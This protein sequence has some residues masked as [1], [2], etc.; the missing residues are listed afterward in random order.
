VILDHYS[1]RLSDRD[2]EVVAH[3]PPGGNWRNLPDDFESKR[4]DQIRRS[5]AA[6]DGSR[7]TYYGRLRWDHPSYTI[8]TYFN[9]PGNG[10]FIHPEAPRLIT[11]REAARLQSFPDS[12]HFHGGGRSRFVQVGNA[13]PPLLGYQ[14][15]RTLEAGTVVD[16]FAGAGGLSLGFEM[17]GHELV[18][19]ADHDPNAVQTFNQNRDDERAYVLDFGDESGHRRAMELIQA[20]CGSE[21]PAVVIGGP[22]CQG[23]STAGNCAPDD[24]R[25]RLVFAFISAVESLQPAAV[26]MENVP[27]MLGQ[28][29]QAILAEVRLLLHNLGYRTSTIIA[30]AEGYGVPQLR[31][32]LFLMAR[33]DGQMHWPL[34][35]CEIMSPAQPAHQPVDRRALAK[36]PVHSVL[37]A[38]GDLPLDSVQHPDI[39]TVYRHEA[40]SPYQEW[41]RSSRTVAELI[42]TP[43]IHEE[44]EQLSLVATGR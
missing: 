18:A 36:A 32:R 20:R 2:L 5:A 38:I 26:V 16:L 11:I 1:G 15:A 34:P 19:A 23:F 8:S 43:T 21:R 4:I 10:C 3:V 41:A 28:R 27:A 37:D 29:G 33:R 44:D 6:G 13:V 39:P 14:I 9:R 12:Y 24:P 42:P 30:H 35:W 22:P 25:N 17:A 7:S 40:A 31:R